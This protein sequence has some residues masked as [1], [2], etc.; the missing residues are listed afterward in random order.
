M[1]LICYTHDGWE[2]R[3]RPASSRREWMD[4]TPESFAYRCLP[5]S[6][7]NSHGWEMLSPCGFS[8]EWNGGP[9][10]GDVEIAVDPGARQSDHPEALFGSGIL[11]F[12]IA[13]ILRTPPGW[14]ILVGGSPNAMKDGIAPLVGVIETDWSPFTFTM[15][16]R[17]TRPGHRIQFEEN[18]PFAFF[19]PVQRG[20]IE[21]FEPR[22]V[23]LGEAPQLE[24]QFAEW[25]RSRDAFQKRME[26]DPPASPS[27]KWQKFYYRGL[28][29]SGC[30][31]VPDHQAKLRSPAFQGAVKVLQQA[32]ST[33]LQ[34]EELLPTIPQVAPPDLAQGKREWLQRSLL[35]LR[36][37]APRNPAVVQ[38]HTMS[39]DDFL[40]THYALNLPV[41]LTGEVENWPAL[42]LWTPSYLKEKVGS[43][44]IE[45]QSNRSGAER[46]ERN[47]DH[48]RNAMPFDDFIDL[49]EGAAD[50]NDAYITA[51]NSATN[52]AAFAPLGSDIGTIEHLLDP[53]SP[54]AKGM[55]WIGA[56]G[57]FTPL[58][59][60]L[61]N[62]LLVQITGTKH[63]LLVP[64]GETA[65][66]R[67][68]THVFSQFEDLEN[69]DLDQFPELA[70]IAIHRVEL[71]P[72][73]AL[74][75]PLGWW[76]QVVAAD[77][78]VSLTFTNFRWPND[79]YADYPAG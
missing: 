11:T 41:V 14:N 31:H 77:F 30:P 70:D 37:L 28:D 45:F 3:I 51:Y 6:I 2:P 73:Q 71:A 10:P 4:Q 62:K 17:F 52:R 39:A 65:K 18:E 54:D 53:Q 19:F 76:H 63:V 32:G 8:A 44:A 40:A 5:L 57:T 67:N 66:L 50:G 46:Y 33:G 7:A 42:S 22:V 27:E 34:G 60:D 48:H 43:S 64:P 24:E 20:V 13:G 61:T 16:W 35:R 47:K 74:F 29:A 56:A 58:H 38:H 15:N 36:G 69:A 21:Q 75:I 68:D 25:S 1:E 78:S 79:F 59:H 49:V 72:G 12:H 26:A 55:I 23:P 9:A